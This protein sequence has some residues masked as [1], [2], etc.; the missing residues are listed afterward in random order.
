MQSEAERHRNGTIVGCNCIHPHS[1]A[2][3]I[4]QP[5]R[6]Q[7]RPC[8]QVGGFLWPFE[9]RL[10]KARTLPEEAKFAITDHA[11]NRVTVGFVDGELYFTSAKDEACMLD[12]A[13]P[14][15]ENGDAV[16]VRVKPNLT[17][18]RG[19]RN[20]LESSDPVLEA[21]ASERGDKPRVLAVRSQ[22]DDFHR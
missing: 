19:A 2:D 13:R 3:L 21:L 10:K 4:A 7:E 18:L 15:G 16:A 20:H 22:L 9:L 14:G 17:Q 11:M 8:L 5:E 1:V 6:E 12:P